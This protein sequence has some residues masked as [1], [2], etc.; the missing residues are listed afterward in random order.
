MRLVVEQKEK[1]KRQRVRNFPLV[2]IGTNNVRRYTCTKVFTQI[3]KSQKQTPIILILQTYICYSSYN[4]FY[5]FAHM[6]KVVGQT[7]KLKKSQM[8][9]HFIKQNG[10]LNLLVFFS[11]KNKNYSIL[12]RVL[13]EVRSQAQRLDYKTKVLD[14]IFMQI[15]LRSQTMLKLLLS[16][17][18]IFPTLLCIYLKRKKNLRRQITFSSNI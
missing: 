1:G 10:Y 3:H 5:N 7:P 12:L 18:A 2:D 13:S 11:Q 8:H 6:L 15:G 17:Y 14:Y 9:L 16:R 4:K